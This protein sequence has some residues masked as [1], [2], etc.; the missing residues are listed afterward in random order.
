MPKSTLYNLP[1]EK[2]E[3]VVA[4]CIEEFKEHPLGEASV[5]NIISRL[6]VARGTFYKYFVDIEDCYFYILSLETVE[7]H[8][9]F[10]Q[11][12]KDAKFDFG[13]ALRDYGQ[14]IARE[15]YQ[16]DKYALYKNR[17]LN[18]NPSIEM[19]WRDYC[20][21]NG[22]KP[23]HME[24]F[25]SEVQSGEAIHLLKA[26]VHDLVQ[27]NFTEN[28]SKGVFLECYEEQI[29]MV[30]KGIGGYYGSI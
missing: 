29:D 28:W 25:S 19:K 3:K 2:K 15:L 21:Q 26:I 30:I 6:G 17:Y 27:R 7:L 23:H 18:W 14:C 16:N 20:K 24:E 8:D 13:V 11:L 1:K 4:A 22:I 5:A 12:V 9:L 10:V